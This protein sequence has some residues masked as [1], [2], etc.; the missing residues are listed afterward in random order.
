SGKVYAN[1]VAGANKY[2][3]RFE[4][5][6]GGFT[7]VITS[8]TATLVLNWLTQPLVD[9]DTYNVTVAASFDNGANYCPYGLSCQVTIDNTPGAQPRAMEA[10]SGFSMYPNPNRGDQVVLNITDLP[11]SEVL[12]TVDIVDVFGKRVMSVTEGAQNGSLNLVLALDNSLASGMY[13]VQV[14]AGEQTFT[15]RLVINK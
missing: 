14:T 7:R 9:G 11:E 10:A 4:R 5:D 2:R 13:T 6:G 12:V 3:W 1:P 15:E 8:N